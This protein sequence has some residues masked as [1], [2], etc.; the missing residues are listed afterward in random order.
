ML[1]SRTPCVANAPSDRNRPFLVHRRSA[2][3]RYFDG[4]PAIPVMPATMAQ[5]DL[6]LGQAVLEL[7]AITESILGDPGATLQLLRVTARSR[8]GAD[9][10]FSQVSDSVVH[11]GRMGLRRALPLL[12]P[13]AP[14]GRNRA[15][16]QLWRRA[17]I[18]AELSRLLASRS[19]AVSPDQARMAGLL[20][21]VGRLPMIL[22][23]RAGGINLEDSTAVRCAMERE[24]NIPPGETSALLPEQ[25]P[26]IR[27][28]AIGEIVAAAAKIANA[29]SDVQP[30]PLQ[31]LDGIS[32][33][34]SQMR[35]AKRRPQSDRPLPFRVQ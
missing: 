22:G 11:L 33:S 20:H 7:D 10:S 35:Q 28:S 6:L 19:T 31:K 5:L 13:S 17:Q 30:G 3:H 34:G 8:D 15:A 25:K 32:A 9:C 16:W 14:A 27:P 23:W 2:C 4:Q 26:A 12:L 1:P 21:E 24:W 29:V 18:T